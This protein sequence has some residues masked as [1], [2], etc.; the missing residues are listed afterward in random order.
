MIVYTKSAGR[1]YW[2]TFLFA[3][4]SYDRLPENEEKSFIDKFEL[5]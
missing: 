4:K 3:L 5:F 2:K 1:S